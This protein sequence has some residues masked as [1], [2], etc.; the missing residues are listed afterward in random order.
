MEPFTA[1]TGTPGI[2]LTFEVILGPYKGRL[3]TYRIWRTKRAQAYARRDLAKLGVF[4]ELGNDS[5][6]AAAAQAVLGQRFVVIV[7]IQKTLGG[8]EFNDVTG[9]VNDNSYGAGDM[10]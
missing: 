9:F 8:E 2:R 5:Q 10:Q 6:V 7:A 3:C 4:H 1:R